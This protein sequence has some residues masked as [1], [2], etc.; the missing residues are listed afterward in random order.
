MIEVRRRLAELTKQ[1]LEGALRQLDGL[2]GPVSFRWDKYGGSFRLHDVVHLAIIEPE[3]SNVSRM[4]LRY[5][6]RGRGSRVLGFGDAEEMMELLAH[7]I[8][9]GT[10][11]GGPDYTADPDYP[12]LRGAVMQWERAPAPEFGYS[13]CWGMGNEIRVRPIEP[14]MDDA[15]AHVL[16]SIH[17]TGNFVAVRFGNLANL[18]GFAQQVVEETASERSWHVRWRGTPEMLRYVPLSGFLGVGSTPIGRVVLCLLGLDDFAL[19]L[20]DGNSGVSLVKRG[21]AAEINGLELDPSYRGPTSGVVRPDSTTIALCVDELGRLSPVVKHHVLELVAKASALP[22]A[23]EIRRILYAVCVTHELG[24]EQQLSGTDVEIYEGLVANKAVNRSP[25][26]RTRR[27][28]LAW[29]AHHSPLFEARFH[30]RRR[31][32]VFHYEWFRY[33]PPAIV[34]RLIG[35]E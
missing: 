32:Y 21:K 30:S 28:V 10:L 13:H 11:Y 23:R 7:M 31:K 1:T 3:P 19:L 22:G 4:Q 9:S 26:E 14:R 25:K 5:L 33:P 17:P 35:G 8:R 15:L 16:V 6:W 12:Y 27:T 20:R 2:G 18:A 29:L 34:S 24:Q